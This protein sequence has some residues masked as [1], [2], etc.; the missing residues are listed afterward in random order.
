[1]AAWIGGEC[2]EEWMH[3]SICCP[4]ETITA[5]LVGYG[6]AKLLQSFPALCD[7]MGCSP[8][9]SLSMGILQARILEWVAMSSYLI[10]YTPV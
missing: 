7:P 2:G 3:V 6:R 9:V 5:L 4:P 1:M 10:G 8:Q